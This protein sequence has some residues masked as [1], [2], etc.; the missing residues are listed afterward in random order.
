MGDDP[1]QKRQELSLLDRCL[2][3]LETAHEQGQVR[4]THDMAKRLGRF[5]GA[6]PG[7]ATAVLATGP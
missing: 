4:L 5:V 3:E 2:D 1:R 7:R 6:A